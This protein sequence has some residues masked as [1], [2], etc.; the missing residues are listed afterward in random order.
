MKQVSLSEQP[1][2][3]LSPGVIVLVITLVAFAARV[4]QLSSVPPGWRDDELIN[5]LVISQKVLDGDWALYYPDASGHE[6]LYHIL[7]AGM[8]AL[9]GPGVAGIRLISAILGTL[10]VPLVYLVGNRL[11]GLKVGLVAAAGLAISFWALMYSRIGIR[12]VSSPIFLLAT[13]YFFLRGMGISNSVV[14]SDRSSD[15]RSSR[16]MMVD[17]A[18][19]GIFIGMG[20]YT[21]FASRGTPVI[22]LAVLVY[23]TVFYR[24]MLVERW[25]GLLAMFALSFVLAVPLVFTLSSQPESEA[26]IR[27]LAVPLVEAQAGNF[28]PLREHIV[29]T[30]NMFHSDGD[31]EWLYNIPFRPIFAPLVAVVFWS[32]MAI[33]AYY[34]LKPIIRLLFNFYRKL[35]HSRPLEISMPLPTPG[36]EIAGAFL[37]IWWLLGIIPAFVSVPPASLGHTIIAQPATYIAL[38]LPVFGLERLGQ[39]K[40]ASGSRSRLWKVLPIAFAVVLLLSITG[41]D[42]PDYFQKWPS[43]GMTRFL[44]RADLKDLASYLNQHPEM[45]DFG[46]T[47]LLAGPWDSEALAINLA[48]EAGQRPR[49]FDPERVVLLRVG[50]E[51]AQS[52]SGYPVSTALEEIYFEPLPGETAGGYRLATLKKDI[53]MT[54]EPVCF[55]NNLCLLEANY[56]PVSQTLDLT[57]ELDGSLEVPSRQLVS[58][59]PP[60]GIYVGPRLHVFSQ[61]LDEAGE[62]IS[63]DDGIWIDVHTLQSGDRFLQQHRFNSPPGINPISVAF[64]LYDPLTGERIMT[65]DGR[66]H[67]R[68]E[69]GG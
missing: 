44:Y 40:E 66:D 13:F 10:S 42:L 17:F 58:N 9:F 4:W 30:I 69:L 27:E 56:D 33:A 59:P 24:K 55:Q 34:S 67:L 32:G 12:H 3:R 68:I 65:E 31:E 51:Q 36:L 29:R 45:T 39:R 1:T 20:F 8:L 18:L 57:L 14:D 6:A 52:F 28:Q 37:L 11:F 35:K 60:P 38:A 21:Y 19:A 48:N 47:G 26:R 41:R 22:L 49:W 54:G 61:L 15:H 16:R 50:G 43:R 62:T 5:S 63:S 53:A 46:V 2:W 7:N 25:Q 23:I 64:G